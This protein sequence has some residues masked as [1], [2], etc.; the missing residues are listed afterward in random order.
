MQGRMSTLGKIKT[1][2][3]TSTSTPE[4]VLRNSICEYLDFSN[5]FYLVYESK[6]SYLPKKKTFI[7][8][9]WP[10]KLGVSDLIV[11]VPINKTCFRVIFCELK[12]GTK[13]SDSQRIFQKLCEYHGMEYYIVKSLNQ[14]IQIILCK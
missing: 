4:V 6:G 5:A 8:K 1:R 14:F 12:V 11:F 9:K 3:R 2:K 7:P 10:Y 13:Q